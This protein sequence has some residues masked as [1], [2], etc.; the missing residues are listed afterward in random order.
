MSEEV[1]KNIYSKNLWRGDVSRS[2]PSSNLPRTK[3][4]RN[5]LPGI[6]K[7]YG[8]K[9]FLDAPCGDFYWMNTIA[10]HMDI[11]YIGGDI[12]EEIINYNTEHFTEPNIEFIKIDITSDV[13]P[14]ADLMM[15]RDCL[16]HLSYLDI[17]KFFDNFLRSE[18]Q[19]L[20]VTTHKN[21]RHFENKD[22]KSGDWRW[23]DLYKGPFQFPDKP[24]EC[25]EDGGG[26]R[27]M[28]LYNKTMIDNELRIFIKRHLS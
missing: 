20:L 28:V 1:F 2:G 25:I 23:F 8:I 15:C 17:A 12:V 21:I 7:S 9:T 24:L 16:F 14:D 3:N 18:I 5:A 6:V 11:K 10:R 27:F 13:L 26:D 19:Y 22:I 4:L